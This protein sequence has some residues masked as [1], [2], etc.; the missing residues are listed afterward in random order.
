MGSMFVPNFMKIE[1]GEDFFVDLALNDP[2]TGC[3]STTLY[4]L[5]LG[6]DAI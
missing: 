6:E 1:R 2:Y 3:A 4:L 5:A